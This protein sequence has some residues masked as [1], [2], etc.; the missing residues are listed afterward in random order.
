MSKRSSTMKRSSRKL[1]AYNVFVRKHIGTVAGKS[2][3]DKMR[4][5]ARLWRKS[6]HKS[7][8][9]AR[10]STRKSAH[11]KTGV[12]RCSV[13]AVRACHRSGRVCQTSKAGVAR[14]R[15]SVRKH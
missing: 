4:A 6:S 11:K 2:P 13:K 1:S 15:K 3:K 8:S 14:C 9:K 5:V 7:A 10:K 12:R